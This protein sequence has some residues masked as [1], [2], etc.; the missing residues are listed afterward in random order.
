MKE[1]LWITN[2]PSPYR[3]A[4]FNLLGKK[5]YKLT[6]LFEKNANSTRDS[7]WRTFNVDN[8]NAVFLKGISV[9]NNIAI[10]F[11]VIKHLIRF[12]KKGTI[13]VHNPATPTGIIATSYMKL[14]NI[15][16]SIESDGGLPK[17]GL[18]FKEK[19][20]KIRI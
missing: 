6:V 20:K 7:T 13:I 16:Y 3:V 18:G 8:F 4:F 12:S 2:V 10:S 17:S 11:D 15:K 1:V 14:F 9:S 19:L 5:C